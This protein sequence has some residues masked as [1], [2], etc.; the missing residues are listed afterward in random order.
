M[1][2][3]HDEEELLSYPTDHVGETVRE[4]AS[5]SPLLKRGQSVVDDPPHFHTQIPK[6]QSHF[7]I[8]GPGIPLKSIMV[9]SAVLQTDD[10]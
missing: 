5:K 10:K 6:M 3:W 7:E 9:D 4:E 8:N 1:L 2:T